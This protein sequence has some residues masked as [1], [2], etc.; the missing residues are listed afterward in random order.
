MDRGRA[1]R[2]GH[3]VGLHLLVCRIFAP[4]E[5]MA[6]VQPALDVRQ[7]AEDSRARADGS[8][9]PGWKGEDLLVRE[10]LP[11]RPGAVERNREGRQQS[12]DRQS[13]CGSVHDTSVGTGRK[14]RDG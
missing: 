13:T 5:V 9:R 12:G 6:I 7:A 4:L 1:V 11:G 3:R 2:H 8:R 14:G 10:E